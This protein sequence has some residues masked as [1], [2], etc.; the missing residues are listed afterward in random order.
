LASPV[1][2][3]F[4]V[5]G[6]KPDCVI[7]VHFGSFP[8]LALGQPIFDSGGPWRL[9]RDEEKLV[10]QLLASRQDQIFTSVMAIFEPEFKKGELYIHSW[11]ELPVPNTIPPEQDKMQLDPFQ[12]P[13][14]ELLIVNLLALNSGL[15]IHALGIVNE[16]LGLVFSGVSGAGKSTLA[17]LWKK[18]PVRIL[19][20]D[21]ISIRKKDGKI[22]AYGT[23]W[24]GDAR[25]SLPEKAPLKA[26]YFIVHG[27]ENR[28]LPLGAGDAAIRL[29]VRS[30][31]T[32]YLKQVME[33]TLNFVE[34]LAEKIPCFEFQFTPDQRAIDTVLS[35]VKS[36]KL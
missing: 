17:E 14:D 31:P 1:D 5:K 15:H 20:D 18:R 2:E 4:L 22:W 8:D 26:I 25:I 19:S 24:H 35:Y 30:F 33:S 10:F 7:N 12:A 29:I 32:Y 34:E 3:R 16:G 28:I 27:K 13:L 11:A 6:E 36:H 21:R 23:P 9:Y